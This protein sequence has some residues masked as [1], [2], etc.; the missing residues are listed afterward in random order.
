VSITGFSAFQMFAYVGVIATFERQILLPI[1]SRNL[2]D[3]SIVFCL[4]SALF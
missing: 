1:N 4:Q 3:G 2:K